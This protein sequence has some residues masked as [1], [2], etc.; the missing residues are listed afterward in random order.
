MISGLS[1]LINTDNIKQ[2][3][4]VRAVE[5]KM[6]DSGLIKS[7]AEPQDKF[8]EFLAAEAKSL[9]I[10]ISDAP[11]TRDKK[12]KSSG[13][14][15]DAT[16]RGSKYELPSSSESHRSAVKYGGETREELLRGRRRHRFSSISPSPVGSVSP[17]LSR[18]PSSSR[19]RS[20]SR[21]SSSSRSPR[22]RSRSVSRSPS[23]YRNLEEYTREQRRRA[24]VSSVVGSY[25]SASYSF[26]REKMED[27]KS[28]MLEQIDSIREA[29]VQ[30]GVSLD[31]VAPLDKGS[32][33]K[34]VKDTLDTLRRKNDRTR[35]RTIAEEGIL[36]GAHLL[37]KMFDG[38]RTWAGRWRPDLTGWDKQVQVKLRRMRYDTSSVVS[39]VLEDLE[40]SPAMRIAIELVP[41]MFLYSHTRE[42]KRAAFEDLTSEEE[43]DAA[44]ER[45][46]DI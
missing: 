40:I 7:A 46:R 12:K 9:G 31:S 21:S 44:A 43:T 3:V 37:E 38:K 19:S 27:E 36:C 17:S 2:G 8:Q 14:L 45:I 22:S 5:K 33:Y 42:K 41:N 10:D 20:S 35:C 26:D 16:F 32:T 18:S 13:I 4:D 28:N 25:G 24:V 23:G 6:I 1:D 15:G 39:G 11:S 29:L 30:D 34:E